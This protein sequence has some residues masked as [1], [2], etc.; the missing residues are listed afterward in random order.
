LLKIKVNKLN[1]LDIEIKQLKKENLKE[2]NKIGPNQLVTPIHVNK[3]HKIS[4]MCDDYVNKA[5]NNIY[6]G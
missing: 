3:S 6:L 4:K 5:F 2:E 1:D